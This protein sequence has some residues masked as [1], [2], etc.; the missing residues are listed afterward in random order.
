MIS[1]GEMKANRKRKKKSRSESPIAVE[2]QKQRNCSDGKEQALFTQKISF[3]S[4]WASNRETL[5]WFIKS[6]EKF[7]SSAHNS[8]NN[9]GKKK[10]VDL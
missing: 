7:L 6:E 9:R 8:N 2:N 1:I 5:I 4:P 10:G 3:S